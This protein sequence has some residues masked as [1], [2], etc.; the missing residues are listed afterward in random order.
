MLTIL[1]CNTLNQQIQV[2]LWEFQVYGLSLGE[3]RQQVCLNLR[4]RCP[5]ITLGRCGME[6]ETGSNSNTNSN[7][8]IA[9]SIFTWIENFCTLKIANCNIYCFVTNV[10]CD[11]T[12]ILPKNIV[13][14]KIM[15]L[16][17]KYWTEDNLR[18]RIQLKNITTQRLLSM[19]SISFADRT[20]FNA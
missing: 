18:R 19:V 6:E 5:A 20:Y 2:I 9:K 8:P 16:G 3:R 1:L 11:W 14:F 17:R 4:P 15:S 12:S 7:L 13:K 10:W